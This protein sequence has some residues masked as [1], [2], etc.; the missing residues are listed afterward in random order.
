MF[1]KNTE[2]TVV[3]E[4]SYACFDETVAGDSPAP[5]LRVTVRKVNDSPPNVLLSFQAP[6]RKK[7]SLVDLNP[8]T[9]NDLR[10]MFQRIAQDLS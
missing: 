4:N 9:L 1:E 7:A 8:A 10:D 3:V 2:K 5:L 6:G